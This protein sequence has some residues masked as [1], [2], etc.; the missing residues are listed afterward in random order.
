MVKVYL[1]HVLQKQIKVITTS[2]PPK[3]RHAT[4]VMME[5][6]CFQWGKDMLDIIFLSKGICK[7]SISRDESKLESR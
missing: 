6:L 1:P 4:K 7:I 2:L 5:I 3:Q